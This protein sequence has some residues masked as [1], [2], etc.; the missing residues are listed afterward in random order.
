MTILA[1]TGGR[2][3]TDRE[4]VFRELDRAYHMVGFV[5]LIHGGA[6]GVDS[7]CGEWCRLFRTGD[8]LDRRFPAIW[9]DLDG[10]PRAYIRQR[11]DGSRYNV[12]AGFQRNEIMARYP[13]LTHGL[14]FPG[15]NGTAD[16]HGRLVERLGAMRVRDLRGT[17]LAS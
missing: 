1:V 7:L 13:G 9:G 3:F 15:G 8:V 10:V 12:M 2:K 6:D 4:F 17:F 16:M 5:E 11:R 14:V